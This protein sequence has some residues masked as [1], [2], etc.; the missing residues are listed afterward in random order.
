[1]RTVSRIMGNWTDSAREL[2]R[3][4]SVVICGVMAALAVVL[5][6][7]GTIRIG[8][9]IRIGLSGVPERMVNFLYGPVVGGIFGAMLDILEYI[10]TPSG[11][12]FPGFTIS[13]ALTGILYGAFLYKRKLTVWSVLIP[14]ILVRVFVN[15]ILNTYWLTILYGEGFFVLLPGRVASNLIQIPFET[16]LIYLVLQATSRIAAKTGLTE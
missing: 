2:G 6:F 12:F 16:A 9:Y 13:A 1:M 10:V 4:K 3:L 8:S 14:E 15:L 11:A 7:T 5:S